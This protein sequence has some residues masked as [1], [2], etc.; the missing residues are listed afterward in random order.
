MGTLNIITRKLSAENTASVG[1]LCDRTTALTRRLAI[2]QTGSATAYPT[3]H[4]DGL[5]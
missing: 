4:V 1:T 2:A 3:A 5:R